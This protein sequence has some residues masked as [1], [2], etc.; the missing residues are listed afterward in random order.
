MSALDDPRDGPGY[1]L[2]IAQ[3][4]VDCSLVGRDPADLPALRVVLV[5]A[6][7]ELLVKA[8]VIEGV[9]HKPAEIG[10]YQ[11]MAEA[12]RRMAAVADRL[13]DGDCVGA[14]DELLD[15]RSWVEAAPE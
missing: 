7:V 5:L 4:V 1:A 6:E 14:L 12:C 10:W 3:K 13:D 9:R 2:E 11:R 8:S 15:I